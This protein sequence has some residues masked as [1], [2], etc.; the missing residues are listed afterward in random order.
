MANNNKKGF[1]SGLLGTGH[2]PKERD[3]FSLEELARLNEVLQ[4][5]SY[6]T[7]AN[8]EAVVEALRSM[9]ELMIWGDQHD[10]KFFEFFLEAN[11]L[12][13]F[14]QLLRS[15]ENRRGDMAKQVCAHLL[16]GFGP[17]ALEVH[18]QPWDA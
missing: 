8:R 11:L 13:H 12:R 10:P 7:D 17:K 5:N 16:W 6:V 9:A 4:R 14:T 1:W 18:W 2:V 3:R 15:W